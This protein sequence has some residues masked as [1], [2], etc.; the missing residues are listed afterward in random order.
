MDSPDPQEDSWFIASCLPHCRNFPAKSFPAQ[1]ISASPCS[2]RVPEV[3]VSP[4]TAG[5]WCRGK[6]SNNQLCFLRHWG[7][8]SALKLSGSNSW[9]LPWHLGASRRGTGR[10]SALG[11]VG[12]SDCFG[13]P[14]GSS[15][16]TLL[17]CPRP[18]GRS[19]T[20]GPAG[21]DWGVL[22]WLCGTCSMMAC[23]LH[24]LWGNIKEWSWPLLTRQIW[25]D[26]RKVHLVQPSKT[27]G[28]KSL[29]FGK[30]EKGSQVSPSWQM[31][32][33]A[34]VY[35]LYM[36][37]LS[38]GDCTGTAMSFHLRFQVLSSAFL[39]TIMDLHST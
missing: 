29:V 22:P 9:H 16:Q 5:K 27:V 37:K 34:D 26:R 1:L 19:H 23:G 33:K 7:W 39:S 3:P 20:N 11:W 28:H 10:G 31:A 12:V 32:G 4:V 21:E 2:L 24:N 38:G 35:I 13:G 17:P 25:S 15:K 6:R 18:W 30:R 8:Q 36:L 14:A